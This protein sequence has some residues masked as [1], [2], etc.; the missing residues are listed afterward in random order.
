MNDV[1]VEQLDLAELGEGARCDWYRLAAE[2]GRVGCFVTPEWLGTWLAELGADW[3]P[4]PLRVALQ[5]RTALLAPLGLRPLGPLAVG[6]LSFL[7]AGASDYLAP[8]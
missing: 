2:A 7:G 1:Q 5:G 8:L 6:T 4:L 3:Q